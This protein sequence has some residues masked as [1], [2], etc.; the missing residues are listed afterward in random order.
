[1]TAAHKTQIKVQAWSS[2]IFYCHRSSFYPSVASPWDLRPVNGAGVAHHH[3][4]HLPR[5]IPTA[6]GPAPL[7]THSIWKSWPNG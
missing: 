2:L 6:L 4:L 3:L 7:V 1:M 5:S